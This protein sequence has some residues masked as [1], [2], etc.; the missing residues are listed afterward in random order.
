MSDEELGRV[1]ELVSLAIER[2]ADIRGRREVELPE[3]AEFWA[4]EEQ[5]LYSFIWMGTQGTVWL[6]HWV[7]PIQMHIQLDV[8]RSQ[9]KDD[10]LI[11]SSQVV[12]GVSYVR[13]CHI[14]EHLSSVVAHCPVIEPFNFGV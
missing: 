12:D 1:L 3:F 5:V 14:W 13:S 8:L 9:S 2:V 4:F 10:G 11:S 6:M 7:Y